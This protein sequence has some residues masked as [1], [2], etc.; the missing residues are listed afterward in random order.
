MT[1]SYADFLNA[2]GQRESSG[3]YQAV[4]SVGYLG[5]YQVGEAALI[6]AGYYTDGDTD[7]YNNLWN[8]AWT[9]IDKEYFFATILKLDTEF[10]KRE[11]LMGK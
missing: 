9:L 11:A 7:P 10:E 6:D 5:K 1:S 4:N 3:N 2:L 8:G